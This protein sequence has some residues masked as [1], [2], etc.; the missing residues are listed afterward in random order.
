MK[1]PVWALQTHISGFRRVDGRSVFAPTDRPL[2]WRHR[3]FVLHPSAL[4]GRVDETDPERPVFEGTPY[5]GVGKKGWIQ[6][7]FFF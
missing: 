4:R 3:G 2:R 5:L 6:L 1:R 7:Q